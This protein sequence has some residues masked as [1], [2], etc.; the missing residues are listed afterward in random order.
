MIC[1]SVNLLFLMSAILLNGGPLA[2]SD[3]YG[4]GGAGQAGRFLQVAQPIG[5]HR[6]LA[7]ILVLVGGHVVGAC[8]SLGMIDGGHFGSIDVLGGAAR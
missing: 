1:S 5:I 4:L 6:A 2:T 3:W 7:V 8:C